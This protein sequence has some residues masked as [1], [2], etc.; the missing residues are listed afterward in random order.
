MFS[1]VV[2]YSFQL[3][4]FAHYYN[5]D[6]AFVCGDQSEATRTKKSRPFGR[7]LLDFRSGYHLAIAP[8]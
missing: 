8:P 2:F 7:L 3:I 6:G 1:R 5:A 4:F